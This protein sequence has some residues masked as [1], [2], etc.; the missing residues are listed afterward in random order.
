MP[1]FS[2]APSTTAR[3]PEGKRARMVIVV[4]APAESDE[5]QKVMEIVT[6]VH[7]QPGTHLAED[8]DD[9]LDYIDGSD[10]DGV[11]AGGSRRALHAAP[12]TPE[13]SQRI[14]AGVDAEDDSEP[15]SPTISEPGDP[16]DAARRERLESTLRHIDQAR[17]RSRSKAAALRAQSVAE[18]EA[19]EA[20]ARWRVE[21]AGLQ[22]GNA[23]PSSGGGPARP[24]YSEAGG[25][26]DE[27]EGASQPE[28]GGETRVRC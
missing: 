5:P 1:D 27:E 7:R 20:E 8:D 23:P 9:G 18:R 13:V 21:E 12:S 25:Y 19:A 24:M 17:E 28:P 6:T 22:W 16:E 3:K 11:G 14:G 2:I 15:Y 4:D 10:D 26:S